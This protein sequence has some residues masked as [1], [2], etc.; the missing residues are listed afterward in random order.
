MKVYAKKEISISNF[1]AYTLNVMKEVEKTGEKLV[2]TSQGKPVLI[3]KKFTQQT[4]SPLEKLRG[5]VVKYI[6]P[7]TP[8]SNWDL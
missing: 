8:L 7:T 1:E 3:I 6:S 4:C 2:I 5:S